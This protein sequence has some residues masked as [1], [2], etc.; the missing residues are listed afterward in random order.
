M[1]LHPKYN[2]ACIKVCMGYKLLLFCRNQDYSKY[3][4]SG[5]LLNLILIAQDKSKETQEKSEGTTQTPA[6]Q[7][8]LNC[9]VEKIHETDGVAKLLE[10][11]RGVFTL[12]KAKLIL[13]MGTLPPTTLML[14]SFPAEPPSSLARIG[15][16]FTSHFISSIIARVPI[17]E[18][19]ASLLSYDRAKIMG[20]LQMAAVYVAGKSPTSQ[21]QYHIQLTAVI[22]ET[23][24][25]NIYD[26]MRHLPDVVAA[27]TLHQLRTSNG[28]V[29]FVCAC[30]GQLDHHNPQNWY[31]RN[32][33]DD[34]TC[35][36]TLQCVANET[37]NELWDVM[38]RT[39]FESLENYLIPAGQTIQYWS[40]DK[41]DWDET[42]ARP[43][44][45]EIRVPGLV[46]EAS[47]MW[48]GDDETAP[49]DLDYRFRGVEN[50]YLTGGA[51]WP[52]GASWNP[53]C[54]MSGLAMDLADKLT[55]S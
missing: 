20:K 9:T 40:N 48:I 49:V 51:L 37:D 33:G 25:V 3:A 53:T 13:A 23:P 35:N 34:L 38:D 30:L 42:G 11:N 10:T 43:T 16:R 5:P 24:I 15:T 36:A 32:D 14:N 55:E 17:V 41:N 26:T 45:A 2:H 18:S 1:P 8:V 27:P 21:H 46:H 22:D 50:V 12:G 54:A 4:A 31:R 7:V 19:S 29:L 28:Y 6:L 52:T 44:A 39:T 47:T